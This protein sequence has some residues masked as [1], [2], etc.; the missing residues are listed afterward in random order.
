MIHMHD[1]ESTAELRNPRT[2]AKIGG[3]RQQ[4]KK[5]LHVVLDGAQKL[6]FEVLTDF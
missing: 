3:S 1:V 5:K 2:A 4:G 6:G